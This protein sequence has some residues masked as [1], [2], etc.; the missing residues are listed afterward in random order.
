MVYLININTKP[1]AS[2]KDN[3]FVNNLPLEAYLSHAKE[4]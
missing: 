1:K 3:F 4:A 2:K